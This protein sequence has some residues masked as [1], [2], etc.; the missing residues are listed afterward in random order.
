MLHMT[1]AVDVEQVKEAP[2]LRSDEEAQNMRTVEDTAA[3]HK[4]FETIIGSP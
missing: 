2:R 4:H 1:L 3:G